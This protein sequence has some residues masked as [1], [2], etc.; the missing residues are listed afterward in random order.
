M[1]SE[2]ESIVIRYHVSAESDPLSAT[3][4][5]T[6]LI[7]GPMLWVAQIRGEFQLAVR[8]YR[9]GPF[10]RCCVRSELYLRKEREGISSFAIDLRFWPQTQCGLVPNSCLTQHEPHTRQSLQDRPQ[11]RLLIVVSR[12]SSAICFPKRKKA[13]IF[14]R[15]GLGIWIRN[16]GLFPNSGLESRVAGSAYPWV[17]ITMGW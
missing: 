14:I 9:C 7:F 1:P 3:L 10:G 4:A 2:V 17:F 13:T 8:P 6:Y 5:Q 15:A 11:D 12:K 16:G